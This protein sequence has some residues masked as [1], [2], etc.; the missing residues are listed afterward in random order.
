MIQPALLMVISQ[1]YTGANGL[2][3]LGAFII[4]AVCIPLCVL[5]SL[6]YL[7]KTPAH[8]ILRSLVTCLGTAFAVPI[9]F[10]L[11]A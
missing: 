11:T 6:L 3:A 7:R 9:V 5:I 10:F 1:K 4:A 8:G 2:I